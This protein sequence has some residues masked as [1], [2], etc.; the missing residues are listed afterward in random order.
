MSVPSAERLHKLLHEKFGFSSF[1]EGQEE[2]IQALFEHRRLLC[3][4]PTGYGKSLIYQLASVLLEGVTLV[5]SPL[6]AL[7]RDQVGHLR[8]RFD[9]PAASINT[10]QSTEENEAA[11]RDALSGHLRILFIAPEQLDNLETLEFLSKL[12][13]NLLVVDEAHC[14]STWGHDFRPSYRQIIKTV[15]DFEKR[16]PNLHILGL[17]ATADVRT[18]EDIAQQLESESKRRIKVLRASMDRSNITLSIRPVQDLSEKLELLAEILPRWEGSG[19]LYCSTRENTEIVAEY[20]SKQGLD[21]VSY[22]AGYD[23]ARK[24][25]LQKDFIQGNYKAIAAT[26]ALGM[27]I[28][29]PDVRFIVHVDI[30]GSITAYYQEVGRAGRD[31]KPAVGVLFFDRKDSRIQRHFIR[32]AQPS[33]EDFENVLSHMTLDEKGAGPN[34]NTIKVRSGLHPTKVNVILAEL[35]EQGLVEKKLKSRRQVYERTGHTSMVDLSRYEHQLRIR[36]KELEAMLR[37][38]DGKEACLMH[39]LRLALGDEESQPC[40][41]C[42]LCVPPVDDWKLVDRGARSWLYERSVPILASSRP[43]MS[44]GLALLN[45]EQR[46]PMFVQF[47]RQRASA[48][49]VISPELQALLC[50]KLTLLRKEYDVVAVATLPSRTWTQQ[51]FTATLVARELGVPFLSDLLVWTR[52]PEKRQGELL[53]NDQRRANVKGKMGVGGSRLPRDVG[54]LLLLDDYVGSVNS[55]KEAVRALRKQGGFKGDIVPL[56]IARVRWKL[57]ASGML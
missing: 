15:R 54:A 22:H 2:A 29:K 16:N 48:V 5:L 37:Y 43:L 45:S 41:R 13:V 25:T 19:I 12:P 8:E 44:K 1:R 47:M 31:G 52:V 56:T 17:T 7:V 51:E 39:A 57:G 24:R 26:N 30:P 20:L 40:G 53:N 14:I 10:D 38:G 9:I 34:Q 32:S 35:M 36:T 50:D 49:T 4:Q 55:M 23:P 33:R 6:L 3:I 21:V 18:E 27:G 11:R 28:D 46:S 42:S